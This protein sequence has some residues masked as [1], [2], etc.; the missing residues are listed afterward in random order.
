MIG[1]DFRAEESSG[2]GRSD[3]AVFHGG[4]VFVLEFKAVEDEAGAGEALDGAIAQIRERGYGE[5]YR[6]R[7]EPVHL[8]GLV[9]GG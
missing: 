5:K 1:L 7:G 2:Q 9:F 8:M 6:S 4:Q 3:M